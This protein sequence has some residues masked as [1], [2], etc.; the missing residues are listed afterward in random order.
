MR[1]ILLSFLQLDDSTMAQTRG[2]SH[3]VLVKPV[4]QDNLYLHLDF[5]EL[6]LSAL[7]LQFPA[8]LAAFFHLTLLFLEILVY[9]LGDLSIP[10]RKYGEQVL[11]VRVC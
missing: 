4:K 7:L 1:Q 8:P 9:S 2:Y 6:E 3:N 10:L 5:G 11:E